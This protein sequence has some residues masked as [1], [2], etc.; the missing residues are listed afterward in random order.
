MRLALPTTVFFPGSR[1]V[2]GVL[3]A[4]VLS[5]VALAYQASPVA[6]GWR[7]CFDDPTLRMNGSVI[8]SAVHAALDDA[9]DTG[10]TLD[11]YTD[12]SDARLSGS[13]GAGGTGRLRLT[14]R[15][16]RGGAPPGRV[17]VVAHVWDAT[18]IR[19]TASQPGNGLSLADSG[20]VSGSSTQVKF[21]EPN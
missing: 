15:L 17:L 5:A 16:H 18:R 13:D 6:A 7:W 2:S 4:L 20:I 9:A 1:L 12:G 19:L 21:K 3:G 8:H 11:V 14:V 10:G